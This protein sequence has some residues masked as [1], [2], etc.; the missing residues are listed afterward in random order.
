MTRNS[1]ISAA[2]VLTL[3][4]FVTGSQVAVA[5]DAPRDLPPE[6][7][8]EVRHA[9]VAWLECE[10]CEEGQLE[11]V[12]RL[13]VNA[14]PT[15]GATLERGPSSASRERARRHLEESYVKIAEHVKKNPE[16]K[17]EVSQ[18]EY[19]KLYLENYTANYK[20]RSAEALAAIGGEQAR[21]LL[22]EAAASKGSRADVQAAIEAAAKSAK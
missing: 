11:A 9:V 20:V 5:Q 16:E 8:A 4:I 22:A 18:E 2:V 21:K 3:A 17:L 1:I 14:V 19:V 15:L 7:A 6:Q 10:E 13:G 12:K